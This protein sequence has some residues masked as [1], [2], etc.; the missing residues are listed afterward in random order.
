MRTYGRVVM[1]AIAIEKYRRQ[2]VLIEKSRVEGCGSS[3]P[4][5]WIS[6]ARK[7]PAIVIGL[8]GRLRANGQR[9]VRN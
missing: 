9:A 3:R 2:R 8:R 5:R 4:R 6:A 1:P 7:R